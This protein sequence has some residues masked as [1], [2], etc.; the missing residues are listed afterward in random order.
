MKTLQMELAL[1]LYFDFRRNIIVTNVSDISQL[2]RTEADLLIVTKA[3]YATSIEIKVSKSDLIADKKKHYMKHIYNMHREDHPQFGILNDH[4]LNV[5][6][7]G[8]KEK[9]Y[10]VPEELKDFA[11]EN[12]PDWC[13]LLTVSEKNNGILS[14]KYARFAKKLFPEKWDDKK[15]FHLMHLGCM[16]IFTLKNKLI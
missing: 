13:G 15:L 8:I 1:M 4:Y 12:I 6:F 2:V 9:Y 16:R 7:K 14:V 11:L 5:Y 3:G 10:A